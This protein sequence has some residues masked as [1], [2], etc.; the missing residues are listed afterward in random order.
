MSRI[1]EMS[2]SYWSF[3][4]K[5]CIQTNKQT[6]IEEKSRRKTPIDLDFVPFCL[7]LRIAF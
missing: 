3:V 7:K 1:L 4:F 6:N 2:L 5:I